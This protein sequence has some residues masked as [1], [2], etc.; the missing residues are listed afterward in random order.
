MAIHPDYFISG[1]W[2]SKD[3]NKITHFFIH[4]N[5]EGGF[6]KGE[7]KTEKEIIKLFDSKSTM[8]TLIWNYETARWIDGVEVKLVEFNNEKTIQ[9][10]KDHQPSDHLSKLINMAP[11]MV[12]QSNL[13]F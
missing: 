7:I 8:A 2:K 11:V 6:K 10:F 4:K 12:T 1:I 9:S 13:F 3:K 5:M